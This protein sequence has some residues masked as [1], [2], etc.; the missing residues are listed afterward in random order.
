MALAVIGASDGREVGVSAL[1]LRVIGAAA[2]CFRGRPRG[3]FGAGSSKSGGAG[4]RGAGA[5]WGDN[6]GVTNRSNE[7]DSGAGDWRGAA[8]F[9]DVCAGPLGTTR[10]PGGVFG[11][12][13]GVA[14]D[15]GKRG[16]RFEAGGAT[17]AVGGV[18]G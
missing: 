11:A 16:C 13:A 17:S 10:D 12:V 1:K 2:G 15:G 7:G 8:R 4:G 18:R 5:N 9:G 6:G 14:G 3:R